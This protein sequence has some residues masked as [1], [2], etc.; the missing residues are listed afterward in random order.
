MMQKTTSLWILC[1]FMTESST[2][3]ES[4][5]I[6]MMTAVTSTLGKRKA[7]RSVA[8]MPQSRPF[9]SS[10]A[11]RWDIPDCHVP[12]VLILDSTFKNVDTQASTALI[13]RRF[14]IFYLWNNDGGL[15]ET[16][17]SVEIHSLLRCK[18]NIGISHMIAGSLLVWFGKGCVIFYRW[19][20]CLRA[21]CTSWWLLFR[22]ESLRLMW[23]WSIGWTWPTNF[24]LMPSTIPTGLGRASLPFWTGSRYVYI[25]H[26]AGCVCFS[27]C[28]FERTGNRENS[29]CGLIHWFFVGI[30]HL[31]SGQQMSWWSTICLFQMGLF[32]FF[33]FFWDVGN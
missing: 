25:I 7:L 15:P 30:I 27:L 2:T 5:L 19:V 8:S 28:A 26:P 31:F 4:L 20:G 1:D 32:I 17:F 16:F 29:S 3:C 18:A 23:W 13:F 6:L 10:T 21:G 11:G 14:Q 9:S 33:I 12:I 22:G 24:T